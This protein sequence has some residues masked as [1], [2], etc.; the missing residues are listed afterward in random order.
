LLTLRPSEKK[1][2]ETVSAQSL[3]FNAG[4]VIQLK[5]SFGEVF[6][7]GWDQSSVEITVI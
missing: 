3:P 1:V 4:G 6:V 5:D 2:A 7:E